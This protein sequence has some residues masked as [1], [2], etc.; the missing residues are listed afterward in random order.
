MVS[1]GDAAPIAALML[2]KHPDVPPVLTHQVAADSDEIAHKIKVA[3]HVV[4]FGDIT[5][6]ISFGGSV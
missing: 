3:T 4:T 2:A 6:F 5:V 1:F